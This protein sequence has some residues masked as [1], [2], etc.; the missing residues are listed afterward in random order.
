VRFALPL[1]ALALAGCGSTPAAE[2]PPPADPAPSPPLRAA[3]A[4]RVLPGAPDLAGAEREA[5][6]AGRRVRSD[7]DRGVLVVDGRPVRVPGLLAPDGVSEAGDGRVAVVDAK[8]RRLALLDARTL[9]VLDT[10]PAGVGPTRVVWDGDRRFYVA[11]T[12][13]DGFLVFERRG[14]RELEP[15]RYVHL[16]GSPWAMAIDPRTSYRVWVALT[17]RNE[18]VGLPAHG[19]PRVVERLPTVRGPQAV[20]ADPATGRVTVLG[21]T[22]TQVVDDPAP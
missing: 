3:P 1:A 2:L 9:R 5:R 22:A 13:G 16:P 17:A 19:R 15:V 4:G 12:A 11:D 18:L 20:S 7:R 21:A 6:A 8:Q 10:A 14:D